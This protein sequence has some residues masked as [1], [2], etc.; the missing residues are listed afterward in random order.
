MTVISKS[1]FRDEAQNKG[2]FAEFSLS[3]QTVLLGQSV[4]YTERQILKHLKYK[5]THFLALV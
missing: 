2:K 1:D 3:L 4:C 5:P